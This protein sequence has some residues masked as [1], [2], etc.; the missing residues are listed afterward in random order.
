MILIN[1]FFIDN[2]INGSD[3][4]EMS[5]YFPKHLCSLTLSNVNNPRYPLSKDIQLFSEGIFLEDLKFLNLSNNSLG[6]EGLLGFCQC[7]TKIPNLEQLTLNENEIDGRAI[8]SL[9]SNFSC[10]TNLQKLY[11]SRIYNDNN[12]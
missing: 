8:Y 12:L 11:L 3:I 6:Y 10:I 5:K 4:E 1:R 9:A 7:L 2:P